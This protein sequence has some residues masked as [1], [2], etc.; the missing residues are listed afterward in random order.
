MKV[1]AVATF[2]PRGDDT[3]RPAGV[4][5]GRRASAH[6]VEGGNDV[7]D[8]H[9]SEQWDVSG[10]VERSSDR[11]RRHQGGGGPAGMRTRRSATSLVS[12]SALGAGQSSRLSVERLGPR[13]L[14][15]PGHLLRRQVWVTAGDARGNAREIA[16][17][18]RAGGHREPGS[19]SP[20][21]CTGVSGDLAK[22]GRDL[23]S[24]H[25]AGRNDCVR[26]APGLPRRS[27]AH[28][29]PRRAARSASGRRTH[30]A[31]WSCVSCSRFPPVRMASPPPSDLADRPAPMAPR[32]MPLRPSRP[33]VRI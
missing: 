2:T 23:V 21:A 26:V 6:Q 25:L 10:A 30:P 22:G 29:L 13:R 20:L 12:T 4:R 19:D 3:R 11:R 32:L 16:E 33:K 7:N 17:R 18:G 9:D 27:A 1:V 15:S 31:A 24:P 5:R 8:W 28:D 14:P